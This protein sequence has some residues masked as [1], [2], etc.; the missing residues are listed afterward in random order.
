MNEK[1]ALSRRRLLTLGGAASTAAVVS[2][3]LGEAA[4]YATEA[5]RV[6]RRTLGKT[7]QKVPILLLGGGAGFDPKF[8]HKIARA[9]Q[10]G[11]DY[12]DA[13]RVYAGGTCEANAS[14]TLERLQALD[15]VWITSKSEAR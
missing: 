8:D 15:K 10:H 5:P 2:P 13:A 1:P 14:T 3:L 7:G 4:A 9:L 6:P 12:V 11:V